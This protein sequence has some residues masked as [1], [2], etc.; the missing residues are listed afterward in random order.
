[1]ARKFFYVCAGL[2]LLAATLQFGAK[3]A[4]AQIQNTIW[5]TDIYDGSAAVVTGGRVI[6]GFAILGGQSGP[7][8]SLP[9]VPGSAEIVAFSIRPESQE[10]A[11]ILANGDV[12]LKLYGA[13]EWSLRGNL[14]SGA[15][16]VINSSWGDLKVRSR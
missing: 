8:V 12:Y 11:A 15:T 9:P 7:A 1:M 16:P 2:F 14:L 10:G 5:T 3:R 4:V 6:Q 13:S